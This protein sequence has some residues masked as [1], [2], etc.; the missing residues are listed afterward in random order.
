MR[1]NLKRQALPI[2]FIIA[3]SL[4]NSAVANEKA[5]CDIDRPIIFAGFDWDSARLHN[6]VARFILEKGYGCKTDEIPGTTIPL[7][8][9]MARGDIDVS[10]EIWKQAVVEVWEEHLKAGTVTEI[11]TN[12]DDAVQGIFIPRWLVEGEDAPAP[13]L[14]SVAQLA[15]YKQL[16][17][18]KEEPEKGRFYNCILGW[19]C[20]DIN[21][22]KL[23]AYGLADDFVDFRPGAGAAVASAVETAMLRKK[24]IAFYYWTPSWLIGRFANELVMLEEP[25]YE[26]A[27][28]KELLDTDHPKRATAYPL[29]SVLIGANTEFT[30]SSPIVTEFLS[31]YKTKSEDI[32]LVLDYMR[33]NNTDSVESA[34]Y[35]LQ[36]FPETWQ[37]WVPAAVA[38]NV[39]SQLP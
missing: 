33:E 34:K 4:L 38:E 32:S 28:W 7:F 21:S 9:G 17:A 16:F 29:V 27:I 13:D 20:A 1:K 19:S 12:F 18:D 22:K 10:M 39:K 3:S 24:P 15:N 30:K 8:N 36:T 6:S 31:K 2:V 26:D 5:L 35:F 37:Q 25:A 14:K 23:E 11:G